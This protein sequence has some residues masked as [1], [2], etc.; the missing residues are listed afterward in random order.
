MVTLYDFMRMD[1]NERG[2]AVFAGPCLGDRQE[3]GHHVQL[4]RVD[5]FYVEV[6]YD[7][8]ANEITR[9]RPFANPELLIPYIDI[10]DILK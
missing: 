4:Y 2:E 6:F 1:D 3:D 9:F 7:P 8:A 5:E 10:T